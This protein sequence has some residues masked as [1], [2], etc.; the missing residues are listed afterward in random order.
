[1]P[2]GEYEALKDHI[3]RNGVEIPILV[4]S[5]GIIIDGH[6][7]Y[8]VITE[9][10]IRKYPIRVFGNISEEERREKAIALN[11]FR[12]QLSQ[13]ERRHWLEELI[14]LNP[15]RSSRDLAATAKVSQSTAARA[16]A[17][18][19]STE[20]SDSVEVHG[21]NGKSYSYKPKPAVSVENPQTAK[22]AGRLLESLGDRAPEGGTTLRRLRRTA[23]NT[24]LEAEAN[25]PIY[26][27]PANIVI[28]QGDFRTINWC[29]WEGKVALIVTDPPWMDDHAELR[30]PL[31]RLCARLLGPGGACLVYCGQWNLPAFVEVVGKYLNWTWE[32][33][34]VNE[35]NGGAMRVHG[36]VHTAW[37]PVLVYSKGDFKNPVVVYD[38]VRTEVREKDLHPWQS[39][40]SEAEYFVRTLS[41]PGDLIV[42][43]C[44]GSGTVA[45]AVTRIGQ[46]RRFVGCDVDPRCVR[47]ATR[48][49][50][51]SMSIRAQAQPG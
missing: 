41:R 51:E 47:I 9:L 39:P 21:H 6:E 15:H 27:T 35:N 31:A 25:S 34:C 37:R 11:L 32:I 1:L 45:T 36:K 46:G 24:K 48:R 10:G 5:E 42:D 12:R 20:S 28:K 8:R 43:P 3:A 2:P 40:L 29:P 17:R 50:A 30:E 23:Y 49:V 19:L 4:T 33:A 22:K 18:V 14:R 7:R 13:A 44:L 38:V 16:K 26:K